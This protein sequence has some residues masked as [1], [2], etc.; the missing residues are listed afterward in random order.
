MEFKEFFTVVKPG[1]EGVEDSTGWQVAVK[2]TKFLE[3]LPPH[4][5][6]AELTE[7]TQ[8]LK[9]TL[10][11]YR[12]VLTDEDLEV[13]KNFGKIRKAVFELDVAQSYLDYLKEHYTTKH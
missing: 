10:T 11:Q 5:A 6:I 1:S 13:P 3:K 7:Y 2:P 9:D 4:K 8:D 12:Q